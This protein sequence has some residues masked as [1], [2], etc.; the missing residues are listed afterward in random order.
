MAGTKEIDRRRRHCAATLSGPLSRTRSS[1]HCTCSVL[2]NTRTRA[3]GL[4]NDWVYRRQ[5]LY[6]FS[7]LS[8]KRKLDLIDPSPSFAAPPRPHRDPTATRA[9]CSQLP[10]RLLRSIKQTGIA[11]DRYHP[12]DLRC[13]NMSLVLLHLLHHAEEARGPHSIFSAGY[14]TCV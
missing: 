7:G 8:G 11:V 14:H 10:P 6:L 9:A 12:C 5:L 3:R 4:G 2:L 13:E 1:C